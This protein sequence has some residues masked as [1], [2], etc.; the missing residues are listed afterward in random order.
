M[1]IPCKINPIGISGSTKEKSYAN[2]ELDVVPGT[3]GYRS[4]ITVNSSHSLTCDIAV[5]WGDGSQ[6]ETFNFSNASSAV[7]GHYY[8]TRT[9]PYRIKINGTCSSFYNTNNTWITKVYNCDLAT[10]GTTDVIGMFSYSQISEL[11]NNFT[12]HHG[13]T[14]VSYMFEY[15]I[16][17]TIPDSMTLP[18]YTSRMQYM[19]SNCYSLMAIPSSFWPS[20]IGFTYPSNIYFN[21]MFYNCFRATGT[22]PAN[23][24]WGTSFAYTPQTNDCF[25]GCTSLD[26]YSSIPMAWR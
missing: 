8:Y 2:Y 23:K 5:D 3:D 7:V 18:A 4:L 24:L 1:A 15:S 19:F 16:I 9:K 21:N 22:V 14:D 11:P 13:I 10:M 20:G 26:N 6:V 12:L 17:R 25:Y